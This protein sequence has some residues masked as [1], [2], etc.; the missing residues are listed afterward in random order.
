MRK[1]MWRRY[2][3]S[4]RTDDFIEETTMTVITVVIAV[5]PYITVTDRN[6][7]ALYV[8]RKDITHGNILKR[9]KKSLGVN[10]VIYYGL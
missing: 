1:S 10:E 3:F 2:K 6:H 7:A 4:L 5:T 9:S 8:I